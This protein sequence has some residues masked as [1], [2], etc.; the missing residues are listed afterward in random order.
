MRTLIERGANRDIQNQKVEFLFNYRHVMK[1]VSIMITQTQVYDVSEINCI[2]IT[3]SYPLNGLS[4][5]LIALLY[6]LMLAVNVMDLYYL[7]RTVG[8]NT[9]R[10]VLTIR[11]RVTFCSEFEEKLKKMLS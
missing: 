9:K 1:T 2:K 4:Q 11:T 3:R 7:H 5:D 6:T 10:S 8:V